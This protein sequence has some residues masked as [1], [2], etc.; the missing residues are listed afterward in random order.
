M[1]RGEAKTEYLETHRATSLE[2]AVGEISNKVD[3]DQRLRLS[4]DLH[5]CSV[6]YASL[7]FLILKK[8]ISK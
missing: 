7:T 5:N 3:A 4:S 1:V 6:P 8:Q 2:H